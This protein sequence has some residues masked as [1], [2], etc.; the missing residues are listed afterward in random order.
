MQIKNLIK[1]FL[2]IILVLISF[3]ITCN[4][5]YE[6]VEGKFY[7]DTPIASYIAGKNIII[8]G[9]Y[10]S[11]DL[12]ATMKVYIDNNDTGAIVS[13]RKERED[14]LIAIPGYGGREKNPEPGFKMVVDLSNISYGSHTIK[15]VLVDKDERENMYR[16]SIRRINSRR[17]FNDSRRMDNEYRCRSNGKNLYR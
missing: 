5:A 6:S 2:L 9:W 14:V 10:L 7:I 8:E 3:Y 17:N 1:I 13:E 11:T 15:Y 12:D 16:Y 4:S